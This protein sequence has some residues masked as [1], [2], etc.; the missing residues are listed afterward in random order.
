MILVIGR[1]GRTGKEL[2]RL[3]WAGGAPLRILTR[4]VRVWREQR[5]A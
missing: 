3:P 5:D 2:I 1:C 4:S